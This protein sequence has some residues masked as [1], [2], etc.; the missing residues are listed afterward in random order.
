MNPSTRNRTDVDI[1][2]QKEETPGIATPG[3]PGSRSPAGDE[4]FIWCHRR[5]RASIRR[6]R[7]AVD[8][9]SR[10]YF[11]LSISRG[12]LSPAGNLRPYRRTR[13]TRGCRRSADR[14]Q[15][16][17]PGT[18]AALPRCHCLQRLTGFPNPP[19]L[20]PTPGGM[21]RAQRVV[22][23]PVDVRLLAGELVLDD[24]QRAVFSSNPRLSMRRRCLS[25]VDHSEARLRRPNL[26]TRSPTAASSGRPCSPKPRSLAGRR[27]SDCRRSP[28]P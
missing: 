17:G 26:P 9:E 28:S 10:C 4:R 25:P 5:R 23:H 15:R 24:H 11:G 6:G 19:S 2:P 8:V 14:R 20:S 13:A 7:H 22:T 21:Q 12:C 3:G 27:C 1:G 16:N 18:S